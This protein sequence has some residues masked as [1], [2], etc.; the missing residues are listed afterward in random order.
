MYVVRSSRCGRGAELA[1]PCPAALIL[2]I[3]APAWPSRLR[4]YDA[5][6]ASPPR[7]ADY[8]IAAGES[9]PPS[10]PG[11]YRAGTDTN[12]APRADGLLTLP[13]AE[14]APSR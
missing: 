9:C 10:Q 3:R 4:L 11:S 8:P 12:A 1:D 5:P 2:I 6:I 7:V 14:C 13:F